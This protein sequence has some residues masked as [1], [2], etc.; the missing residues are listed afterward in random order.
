M[1]SRY[2]LT[3]VLLI[4]FCTKRT[5]GVREFVRNVLFVFRNQIFI[6]SSII[7]F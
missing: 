2:L 3:T 6:H 7:V 4:I 1:C 5:S